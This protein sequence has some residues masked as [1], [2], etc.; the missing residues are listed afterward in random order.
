MF[1]RWNI[2]LMVTTTTLIR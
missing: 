2:L 1:S